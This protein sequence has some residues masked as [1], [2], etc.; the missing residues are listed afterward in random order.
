MVRD[1]FVQKECKV[2]HQ[3][4]L[5]ILQIQDDFTNLKV[6]RI[7]FIT[8]WARTR[9]VKMGMLVNIQY[10]IHNMHRGLSGTLD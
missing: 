4:R 7:F 6:L 10:T 9:M 2:S 8:N 5:P 3:I 1:G